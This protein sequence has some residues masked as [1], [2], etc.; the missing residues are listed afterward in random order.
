MV[1]GHKFWKNVPTGVLFTYLAHMNL[2]DY[3]F[4]SFV[5]LMS[6][7]AHRFL[8]FVSQMNISGHRFFSLFEKKKECFLETD[9]LQRF[10]SQLLQEV[11]CSNVPENVQETRHYKNET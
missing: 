1:S 8:S 2:S 9:L 3:R 4:L 6:V 11:L 10:C 5:S 7:S